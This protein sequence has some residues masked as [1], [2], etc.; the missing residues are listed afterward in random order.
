[1][2]EPAYREIRADFDDR[3]IVVYQ[4]C[5]EATAKPA[6]EHQKFVPP[7]SLDRMTWIKPSFQ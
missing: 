3:T 4:A 5:R 1:M 2:T 6:I 7:F